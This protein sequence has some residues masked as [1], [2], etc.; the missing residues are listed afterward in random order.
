MAVAT[1]TRSLAMAALA[2]VPSRL[3]RTDI[4]AAALVRRGMPP[5]AL[6]MPRSTR[7][8]TAMMTNSHARW[9]THGR[10]QG[11]ARPLLAPPLMLLQARPLTLLAPRPRLLAQA[12]AVTVG[13]P[14]HAP[15]TRTARSSSATRSRCRS[16]RR[17]SHAP[18]PC[19][20]TPLRQPCVAPVQLPVVPLA[21]LPLLL[22][23]LPMRQQLVRV[24]LVMGPL[25]I[26]TTSA[27]AWCPT[28]QKNAAAAVLAAALAAVASPTAVAVAE[29]TVSHT[30]ITRMGRARR[31]SRRTQATTAAWAA[32]ESARQG[33]LPCATPLQASEAPQTVAA[34]AAAARAA[35]RRWE[36]GSG[37]TGG[38]L[39]A[40]AGQ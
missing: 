13:Q 31:P 23:P 25:Q 3:P 2:L 11:E 18:R 29:A 26:T 4:A 1:R 22:A 20:S 8:M 12:R 33:C 14:A 5:L 27:R 16:F 39:E 19:V 30:A 10:G 35:A 24:A 17:P 36:P 40:C 32:T 9:H 38:W 21:P 34:T 28:L 15:L 7:S 6:L 37:A